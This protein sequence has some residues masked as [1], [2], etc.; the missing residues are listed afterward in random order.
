[1]RIIERTAVVEDTDDFLD[2]LDELR[3]EH[4]VAV[5]AFDARYV[6]SRLH[7]EEAVEKA[8][9]SFERGENVADTLSM[10]ILL[11]AAGTRQIDVATR[12][13]MRPGEHDA[14]FVLVGDEEAEKEASVEVRRMTH[15]PDGFVY[16]DETCLLDFFGVTGDET[17]AVGDDRL[18]YLVLERVALLDVNK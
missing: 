10:E 14:V 15:E 18:E 11:Y 16:G 9:R 13:G 7:L 5:Q 12:M 1:M 6:V 8:K 4:G 3:E 17:D 2:A